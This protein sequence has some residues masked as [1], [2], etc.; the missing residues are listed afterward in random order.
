M[1]VIICLFSKTE[2]VTNQK[3][4]LTRPQTQEKIKVAKRSHTSIFVPRQQPLDEL[5]DLL[6]HL[7]STITDFLD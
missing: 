4:A 5:A 7:S 2:V 1:H 6:L 3:G